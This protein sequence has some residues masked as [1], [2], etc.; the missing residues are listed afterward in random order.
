MLRINDV[1]KTSFGIINDVEASKNAYVAYSNALGANPSYGWDVL[2]GYLMTDTT[3]TATG[4]ARP[5][6]GSI[7]ACAVDLDSGTKT[8]K[9]YLNGVLITG[10]TPDINS[11][12]ITEVGE[13]WVPAFRIDSS[14]QAVFNFG[15]DSSFAGQLTAQGN[16]DDNDKGDFYYAPPAGYLALCTD[17]LADPSIALPG[18]YFNTIIWSGAQSGSSAPDRAMT[19]VGFQPDMVFGKT[20]SNANQGQLVYAGSTSTI[21][22]QLIPD[23]AY[24]AGYT[25]SW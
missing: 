23:S 5:P 17:N 21:Q 8:I 15:Q 7:L 25:D 1:N 19:G 9:F 24:Q 22:D 11:L 6:G 18:E 13:T 20:R 2:Y 4:F 12:T 3:Q 16:Q 10:G 14:Q